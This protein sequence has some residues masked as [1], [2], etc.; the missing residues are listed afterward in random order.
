MGAD[1][2]WGVQ[3]PV[4]TS[5]SVALGSLTASIRRSR[6][7]SL[8]TPGNPFSLI[9]Q[10]DKET[11]NGRTYTTAFTASNRTYT[12]TS[13]VG[14]GMSVALDTKERIASTQVGGLLPTQ[15]TYDSR[16]RLASITQGTRTTTLSYDSGRPHRQHYQPARAQAQL[17][18]RCG[19]TAADYHLAGRADDRLRVR[20]QRQPY[21]S[22]STGQVGARLRLHL[23]QFAILIR[24]AYGVGDR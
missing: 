5:Q 13:P 24:A 8:G 2:R 11:I 10:T 9:S 22:H 15:F 7:A 6:T 12:S 20:R 19:W 3:A 4:T 17:H 21:V 18:L 23:G 14:R 1:P 16:G